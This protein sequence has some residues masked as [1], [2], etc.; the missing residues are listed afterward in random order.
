[1][2]P[3]FALQVGFT[4]VVEIVGPPVEDNSAKGVLPLTNVVLLL[5]PLFSVIFSTIYLYNSAEFI[6]LLVSQPLKRRDIWLGFY[7]G[8]SLALAAAFMIGAGLPLLF[9]ADLG[10][11]LILITTGLLITFVFVSLAM[12]VTVMTRDKA[13]GIGLCIFEFLHLLFFGDIH[14]LSD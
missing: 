5:V 7:T 3:L 2:L 12:L 8:L 1:M 6:E 4:C 11:S 14:T 9:F 13:R 10:M